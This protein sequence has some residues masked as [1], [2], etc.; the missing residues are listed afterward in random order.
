MESSLQEKMECLIAATAPEE[1]PLIWC[2]VNLLCLLFSLETLANLLLST[3]DLSERPTAKGLYLIW[4]FGTTLVWVTEV[5]LSVAFQRQNQQQRRQS[6]SWEKRI[7]LL[8]AIYFA[9]DS[10]HLL[11]KWK[12]KKQDLD[13]E[14]WDVCINTLVFLYAAYETYTKFRASKQQEVYG[15]RQTT[16]DETSALVV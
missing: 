1:N 10:L 14:I 11:W 12:I 15:E 2:F 9:W 5:S 6:L 8:A 16:I 3:Q 13:E 4:N 7:E